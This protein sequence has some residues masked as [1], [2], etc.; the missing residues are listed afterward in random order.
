MDRRIPKQ[1]YKYREFNART[2][3]IVVNDNFHYANAIT[4]ND[5]L[6]SRP[7]VCPDL[8][9]NKLEGVIM[10][11]VKRRVAAEQKAATLIRG[12]YREVKGSDRA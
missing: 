9:N 11:L 7:T 1:L 12:Q 3:D 10:E 4:F 2:L 8:D 6:D 5:P